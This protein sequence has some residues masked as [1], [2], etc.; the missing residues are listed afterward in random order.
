MDRPNESGS[1]RN[2][3]ETHAESYFCET[4]GLDVSANRQLFLDQLPA[5][6]HLLDL[7]CGAGRDSLAFVQQGHDVLPLDASPRLATLA[8]RH[9]GRPVVVADYRDLDYDAEFD[10]IWACASLLHCPKDRIVAVFGRIV[11]ALKPNGVWYMSFK[12]GAGERYDPAGRFFNDYT[13]DTLT[14]EL[15]R[16]PKTEIMDIWTASPR[17]ASTTS[18]STSFT[19]PAPGPTAAY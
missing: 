6:A 10:G 17:T 13:A 5:H 2:Y 4:I 7:G 16:T 14:A 11:R 8:S 18:L 3:Y 15:A 12:F 19:T 9:I 1:T